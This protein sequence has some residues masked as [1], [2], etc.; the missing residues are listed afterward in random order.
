MVF[1][2]TGVLHLTL[3]FSML[4]LNEPYIF[5]QVFTTKP[6]I[7]SHM[8]QQHKTPLLICPLCQR[9][10]PQKSSL[11]RHVQRVHGD[12]NKTSTT[13]SEETPFKCSDCGKCYKSQSGLT[14]HSKTKHQNTQYKCEI[15][16]KSFSRSTNVARHIEAIHHNIVKMSA[17]KWCGKEF[18]YSIQILKI[19]CGVVFKLR[20][21]NVFNYYRIVWF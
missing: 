1:P 3:F 20:L 9:G 7:E 21:S 12:G 14:I 15:C 13:P 10:F 5:F 8:Q 6:A 18:R 17:C 11:K 4:V 16:N 19:F 2:G